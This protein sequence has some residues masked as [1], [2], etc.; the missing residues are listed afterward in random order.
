MNRR[1]TC[2]GIVLAACAGSIGLLTPALSG[3]V[4]MGGCRWCDGSVESCTIETP[5][6][7][8]ALGGLYLGDGTDCGPSGASAPGVTIPDNNATGVS[9]TIVIGPQFAIGDL[10]V[11]LTITHTWVGDLCVTLEHGG[12]EVELIRRP[13]IEPD[14][15]DPGVHSSGCF[16]DYFAGIR[17]D[18]EGTG[19]PIED[20]CVANLQSPPSYVPNDPLSAFDAMSSAGAWTLTARDGAAPDVGTLVSWSLSIT[21]EPEPWADTVLGFSSQYTDTFWSAAQALGPPDTFAYDD[22]STAWA[23]IPQN[24]S[25]EFISLGWNTPL[26]ASGVTVRETWGNGFVYRIDVVDLADQAHT[27]WTGVD[28]TPPGAPGEL[29]ATWP[30]TSYQ[31]KGVTIHVDTDHDPNTWEE[32][33]AVRLHGIGQDCNANGSPDGC[34][35]AVGTS[36]DA[37]GNDIPDECE[38]PACPWDCDGSGDGS[39]NVADLLALLGQYD[40]GAPTV[41]AGGGSC[42]YSGNGCVDVT[43]LLKLLGHYTTDPNGIGCP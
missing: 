21:A 38:A 22:I 10:D 14:T 23:P 18:D 34:D 4:S 31:V 17:L 16:H 28:P 39:V 13:G 1:R 27:V 26:F 12:T 7:C 5:P 33:D 25:L 32:I 29:V 3:G 20:Q 36:A 35:I 2:D 9:D 43:D 8:A 11:V 15:C 24:G 19:G 40:P 41:C 6:D 37:D 30:A 42:D